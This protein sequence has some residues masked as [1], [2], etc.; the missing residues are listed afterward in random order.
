MKKAKERL[1]AEAAH[2]MTRK[3]RWENF[4]FYYR[5]AVLGGLAATVLV[6]TF[7][8]DILSKVEPDYQ[9]ALLTDYYVSEES[10]QEL[11]T[12]LTGYADDCN[13][14]GKTVVA[15]SSYSIQPDGSESSDPM[16]H[17][18]TVTKLTADIQACESLLFLC[19]DPAAYQ[20]LYGIFTYTDGSLPP[21]EGAVDADR[22]GVPLTE[23]PAFAELVAAD[24][25]DS[26][27]LGQLQLCQR[28]VA[29]HQQERSKDL[30]E[31]LAQGQQLYQKLTA[32]A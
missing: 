7:V 17:M 31:R 8:V 2:P 23:L 1:D 26:E 20:Q 19:S 16:T 32:T 22:L 9:L 14:D 28:M 3:Q 10:R 12:L 11:E 21:E 15:L 29:P 18:A 27:L 30:A 13:G 6:I 4:W 5:W 24:R 25:P